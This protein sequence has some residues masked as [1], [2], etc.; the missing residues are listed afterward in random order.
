M[1][2]ILLLLAAAPQSMIP[3]SPPQLMPPAPAPQATLPVL[4]QM[5]PGCAPVQTRAVDPSVGDGLLWREGQDPV[6]HYLLLDR[7]VGGCPDPIV[8]AHRVPGSNAVGREARRQPASP[9][10]APRR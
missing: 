7:Y 9:V 3:A 5:S 8:V 1:L 10:I 2:P 4:G 6:G